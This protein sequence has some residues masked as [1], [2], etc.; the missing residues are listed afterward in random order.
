MVML[1]DENPQW[2]T[3]S[4]LSLKGSPV[5]VFAYFPDVDVVFKRA[6]AAGGK[7]VM[8]PADM[9]WGDRMAKVIDPF[10]HVWSIATHTRD[11]T[12]AEIKKAGKAFFAGMPK[13]GRVDGC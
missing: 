9:F 7:P 2:N 13:E 8:P 1:S 3:F 5:A 11:M 6:V 12:D 4:P 10:G